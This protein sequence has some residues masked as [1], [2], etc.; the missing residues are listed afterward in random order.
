MFQ[1]KFFVEGKLSHD[2]S[3]KGPIFDH[4]TLKEYEILSFFSV[5]PISFDESYESIRITFITKIR[6]I[7]K[8][9]LKNI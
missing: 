1:Q 6:N 7:K 2:G 5:R 8:I 9:C 4:F 3:K